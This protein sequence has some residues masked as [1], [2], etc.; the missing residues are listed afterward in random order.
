MPTLTA[1]AVDAQR[2]AQAALEVLRGRRD[3]AAIAADY[4]VALTE[5]Q[6]WEQ[7]LSRNAWVIFAPPAPASV[8][9]SPPVPVAIKPA[10]RPAERRLQQL[11]AHQDQLSEDE[12]QRIAQVVHD[13]LGQVLMTVRID[14]AI[15]QARSAPDHPHLHQRVSTALANLDTALRSVKQI[16]NQLR[17]FELELG[18]LAA[19]DWQ[20][21]RFQRE[22]G[23]T[24]RLSVGAGGGDYALDERRT[25]AV[26][27][28]LQEALS[29]I[30]RH[31]VASL[32]EVSLRHEGPLLQID[33][34]D[35]GVGVQPGKRR[36]RAPFGLARVRQRLAALGGQ[37]SLA[38][39]PGQGTAL[40][41]R[42][43]TAQPASVR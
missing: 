7:Q 17:P 14:M 33:V 32:V 12:R 5:L 35:N 9:A 18:L 37:L 19:I 36:A 25:L 8:M 20:L 16:I 38:S 26:Y 6:H 43:P 4:G 15:L 11:L 13:E 29:N 1:H 24:C 21:K 10:P 3:I 27:R 2:K 30:A 23:I 28:I 31:A 34:R 40:T 42:I 41:I 39:P 22:Y